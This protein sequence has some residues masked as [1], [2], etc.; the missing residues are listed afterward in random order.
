MQPKVQTFEKGSRKSRRP[1]CTVRSSYLTDCAAAAAAVSFCGEES[2]RPW[3]THS[4]FIRRHQRTWSLAKTPL[5]PQGRGRLLGY[6]CNSEATLLVFAEI[7]I[8]ITASKINWIC[9]HLNVA[10]SFLNTTELHL[11]CAEIA[12]LCEN[13]DV[14]CDYWSFVSWLLDNTKKFNT[15]QVS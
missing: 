4:S 3:D 10:D 12:Q 8:L 11:S 6:V 15:F 2:E 14:S 1:V 13:I 5:C 7:C 9:M